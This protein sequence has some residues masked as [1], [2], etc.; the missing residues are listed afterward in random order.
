MSQTVREHAPLAPATQSADLPLLGMHCAACANRIEKALNRAPGVE[1]CNVNYATTRATVSYDPAQ[2]D[3]HK[4][5][6]VV[7]DAGYDAIVPDQPRG[8]PRGDATNSHHDSSGVQDAENLA[9]AEEYARQ[10]RK[11]LIALVLTL[12]VAVLGMGG[13]LFPSLAQTLNFAGRE[14]IE[15]VLTSVVLFGAGAEFFRGAH[16]AARHRAADMNTLV[17]IGTFAAYAFSVVA[18]FAPDL[19]AVTGHDAMNGRAGRWSITKP[20]RLS[21]R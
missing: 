9:R 14:W 18:T 20:P 15:L 12:P 21:S 17:A 3:A 7:Q 10:K 16:V 2:T 1:H 19:F 8:Q 5:K 13:H 4:L 6:Q 11:F